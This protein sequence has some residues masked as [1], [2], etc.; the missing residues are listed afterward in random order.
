M[1]INKNICV[2]ALGAMLML[3]V[4]CKKDFLELQNSQNPTEG[5][6]FKTPGDALK[7]VNGIYD[8]LQDNDYLIKALWYQANFLTQ[9]FQNWGSDTFFATYEIPT[10]FGA[11]NNFWNS[12]YA[13]ITRANSAIQILA[14]MKDKGYI[15]AALA[16]RLTGE[17]IFMRG[18]FYY[19]LATE[20]GGVPLELKLITDDGRHPRNTQDDVFAAVVTDMT[21]AAALLPWQQDQAA[22]DIGRA[23][24]GAAYAYMG[25]AQ[26]WQKKYADAAATYAKLEGRYILEDNFENI[27]DYNNQNGK[28]AIFSIQYAAGANG[29]SSMNS[30]TDNTQW[31]SAFCMP[32]EITTMGY[33]Y[34]H[35]K[36]YDSF[37]ANDKR[38][39][40]TVIGPG[41]THPDSKISIA[42]YQN[43][44]N[45]FG[46]INTVGTVA[47]PWKGGDGQRS[48]FFPV[49]TWRDPFVNG[50]VTAAGA[51]EPYQ[52]SA[53][54]Q[55]LMRYGAVLL[56]RSEA[57]F[58]SG[59]TGDAFKFLNQIRKRAGLPD[60]TGD[61]VTALNDEY[62]HE[63]GGEFSTFF[64]L[65]REGEGVASKFVKDK[66]NI[67][68]PAGHELMPIPLPVISA[69]VKITQNPGYQ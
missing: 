19:Y 54:N 45:K 42:N 2:L 10:N 39:R 60:A 51:S 16:E 63:L 12:S 46:G 24:K 69:N 61:F 52:Y 43:V 18:L 33:A 62:R 20:F 68:I 21:A 17:A 53:L 23:T 56:S 37:E 49:K 8:N 59:N 50:R 31:I 67:T 3:P 38:K 34:V 1:K 65:R 36:F 40:W 4:S 26:M 5:S 30:P 22:G 55:I 41:E 32:E 7:L 28:E 57:L 13:G 64:Y 14:T 35:P 25:D 48:G 9:D 44:K 11:L 58:R 29:N 15:S 47:Q 6:L 66:Y 27:H